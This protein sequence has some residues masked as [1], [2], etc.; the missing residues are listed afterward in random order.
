MGP[1]WLIKINWCQNLSS[2]KDNYKQKGRRGGGGDEKKFWFTVFVSFHG[3][4][5]SIMVEVKLSNVNQL[6]KFLKM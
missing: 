4:K 3:I 2:D 5:T 6:E 1:M